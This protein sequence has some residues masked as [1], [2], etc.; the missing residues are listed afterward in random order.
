MP[1]RGAPELALS[2]QPV[3][4]HT[5][6][7]AAAAGGEP[8]TSAEQPAPDPIATASEVSE[9]ARESDAAASKEHVE[10]TGAEKA[11]T[12][13]KEIVAPAV[14][15]TA[16][17]EE[18]ADDT[19]QM[20]SG[21]GDASRTQEVASGG[22]VHIGGTLPSA[23]QQELERAILAER[24]SLSQGEAAYD[25]KGH[26]SR[27]SIVSALRDKFCVVSLPLLQC[28]VLLCPTSKDDRLAPC[29]VP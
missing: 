14:E 16:R 23:M 27:V 12:A 8:L 7:A 29:C 1:P 17:V 19:P 3:L 25:Q 21:R 4:L 5:S 10:Q 2:P 9:A 22:A 28:S 13:S 15:L 18:Q 20:Y 24:I 11:G 6:S 26:K